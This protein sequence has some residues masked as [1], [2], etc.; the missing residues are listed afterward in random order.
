MSTY[1]D[2]HEI[3]EAEAPEVEAHGMPILDLQGWEA[4]PALMNGACISMVS[5]AMER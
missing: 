1:A 4:S 2:N 3:P 5:V